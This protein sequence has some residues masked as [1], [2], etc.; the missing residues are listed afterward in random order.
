MLYSLYYCGKDDGH[1][2]NQYPFYSKNW[3]DNKKI[4]KI[5]KLLKKEIN[6]IKYTIFQNT[7]LIKY[8]FGDEGE[9]Q[10]LERGNTKFGKGEIQNVLISCVAS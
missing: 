3:V 7:N 10:N 6:F 9:I 4:E 8:R 5:P 2:H 1:H